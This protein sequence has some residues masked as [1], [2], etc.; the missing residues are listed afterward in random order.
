ML[1]GESL[2]GWLKPIMW[3]RDGVDPR[4]KGVGDLVLSGK[5]NQHSIFSLSGQV[6]VYNLLKINNQLE[7]NYINNISFRDQSVLIS[8][9]KKNVIR[10]Y[11]NSFKLCSP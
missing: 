3:S 1:G 4:T 6:I 8:R 10:K 11:F 7:I 9:Y 5:L 2:E